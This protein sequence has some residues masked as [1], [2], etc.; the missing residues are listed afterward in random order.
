MVI[1][2]IF[3]CKVSII[4]LGYVGLPLAVEISL[5]II[6]T[7]VGSGKFHQDLQYADPESQGSKIIAVFCDQNSKQLCPCTFI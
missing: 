5:T 2:N 3:N 4:G 7:E 6:S 1:P